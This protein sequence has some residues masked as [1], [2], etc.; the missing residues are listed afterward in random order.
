MTER[1]VL[2]LFVILHGACL[3]T[4]IVKIAAGLSNDINVRWKHC[5]IYSLMVVVIAFTNSVL[6]ATFNISL[7]VVPSVI[8]GSI[9]NVALGSWYFASRGISQNGVAAGWFGGARI[10]ATAIAIVGVLTILAFGVAH[11]LVRAV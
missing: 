5:F 4:A 7:H 8:L 9:G 3:L 10:S 2:I 1:I 6:F 11:V